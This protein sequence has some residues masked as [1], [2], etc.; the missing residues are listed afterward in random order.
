MLSGGQLSMGVANVLI[1]FGLTA[2]T[3]YWRRIVYYFASNPAVLKV[4]V[5][6]M[7]LFLG[8]LYLPLLTSRDF[9]RTRQIGPRNSPIDPLDFVL[10]R[11]CALTKM[12]VV[13]SCESRCRARAVGRGP[14][15]ADTGAPC[16]RSRRER[17]FDEK[18]ASEDPQTSFAEPFR[19]SREFQLLATKRSRQV[20][21]MVTSDL[22]LPR[23]NYSPENGNG[24][25]GKPT[26][27]ELN[28]RAVAIVAELSNS[29]GR[30]RSMG[31]AMPGF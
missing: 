16:A 19:A 1:C 7:L 28:R 22:H 10:D 24:H 6:M 12:L 11:R 9:T 14:R 27:Q 15:D 13:R 26:T 8:I 23:A 18:D 29:I 30:T 21:K 4:G 3:V 31:C 25:D 17:R 5:L 20:R 2:L